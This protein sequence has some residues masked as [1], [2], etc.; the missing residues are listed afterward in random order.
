[1]TSCNNCN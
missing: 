1:M